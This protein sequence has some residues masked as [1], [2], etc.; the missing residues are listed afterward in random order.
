MSI[1][2]SINEFHKK[3]NDYNNVE[4]ILDKL[5]I[6]VKNGNIDIKNDV[7][8]NN[9]DYPSKKYRKKISN[10]VVN[11]TPSINTGLFGTSPFGNPPGSIFGSLSIDT[12]K[13]HIHYDFKHFKSRNDH[14]IGQF[15][16]VKINMNH[17]YSFDEIVAMK[18]KQIIDIELINYE[19]M[20]AKIVR[21]FT[22]L[23]MLQFGNNT[24]NLHIYTFLIGNYNDDKN[25]IV[26]FHKT[27]EI[28]YRLSNGRKDTLNKK[29]IQ[30]LL[31]LYSQYLINNFN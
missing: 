19:K 13:S 9:V 30:K 21:Y 18:E 5:Y 24:I 14:I 25:S 22:I 29:F 8:Y 23:T 7:I 26:N 6:H 12:T 11:S 1:K 3:Y 2:R 31:S 20:K 16:R 28:Y 27:L 10:N 17:Y 15:N 4:D